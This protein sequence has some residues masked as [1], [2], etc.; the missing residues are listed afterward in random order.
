[1]IAEKTHQYISIS[2]WESI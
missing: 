1:M 2:E